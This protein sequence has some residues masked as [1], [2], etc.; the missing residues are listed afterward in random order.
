MHARAG[1]W[2][3]TAPAA[4]A[5]IP[6]ALA[7]EGGGPMNV[8]E[9]VKAILLTPKTEWLVIEREPGD[10]EYLFKNY[11]AILAAIP[12][13]AMFVG[14]LGQRSSD[15]ALFFLAIV[16]YLLAF[17]FSYLV[18]LIVDALAPTFGGQKNFA[19]ALKLT[20]YSYTPMWLAG[21]FTIIRPL[22]FLSVLGLYA[23]Y[24]F[25]TGAPALVKV[26]RERA[27]G[28]TAAVV[29]CAIV[30]SFVPLIIISVPL[31]FW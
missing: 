5:G 19:N 1:C 12:A 13:V 23:L 31:L 29:V 2:R 10:A 21:I 14:S 25:W 22:A 4:P 9:R 30:L 26:P 27:I 28:Y 11:V 3:L 18:A 17:V 8:V 16:G 15:V 7:A 20:V 6:P 24:L